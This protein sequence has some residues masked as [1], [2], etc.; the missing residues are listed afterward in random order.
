[1]TE[2]VSVQNKIGDVVMVENG[3]RRGVFWASM[4]LLGYIVISII[5]VLL[6]NYY[7]TARG[8]FYWNNGLFLD[9]V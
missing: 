1:M 6:F 5:T 2:K 3:W 8:D 7:F 9:E 4:L